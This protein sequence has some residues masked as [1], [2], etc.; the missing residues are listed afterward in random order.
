MKLRI[1]AALAGLA[2]MSAL[3]A[4]TLEEQ[5][6]KIRQE[7][8]SYEQ[9]E[10]VFVPGPTS[11]APTAKALNQSTYPIGNNET[12][13]QEP[14]KIGCF[15]NMD[16]VFSMRDVPKGE[17]TLAL[18]EAKAQLLRY[19]YQNADYGAAEF[20]DHHRILGLL[21]LKDG[22]IVQEH[23]RYGTGTTAQFYSA[24]MAKTVLGMLIGIALDKG[25]IKSIDDT[26]ERYVPELAG[27]AYGRVTIQ[28]L[29][30]MSSGVRMTPF[31]IPGSDE[32]RF[33][34]TERG[35]RPQAVLEFL[36][37][38]PG[39]EFTPGSQFRYMSTDAVVLGY[40][41]T[42]ASGRTVSALCSEWIWQYIGADQ[43][44][45]WRLMKDG[46]EY[47]GGDMFATLRDYGRLGILLSQEGKVG[48]RQVIPKKWFDLATDPD[49]QPWAFKP[50][51]TKAWFG[52][53]FQTWIFPLRTTTF[54]L[55][56]SWGQTIFVQP[57]SRIVMVITSALP[58]GPNRAEMDERHALWYGVLKSLDGYTY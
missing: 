4:P 16:K 50:L 29:L 13:W 22:K 1:L 55:R 2:T 38:V 35:L 53:G 42:R 25:V 5:L 30:R 58:D 39:G 12:C 32:A 54:G 6:E 8:D 36:R 40:V 31:G 17:T 9:S 27:T 56:G 20:L 44:A 23:Y 10:P 7:A 33:F 47:G 15:T 46:V 52:Y 45:Q 3:A 28:Q 26:A 24:S 51:N 18:P 43:K 57:R 14:N 48:N 49:E 19:R 11:A 21:V 34:Q 41:L 37:E